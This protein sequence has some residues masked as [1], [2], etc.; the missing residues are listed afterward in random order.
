MSDTED[1][2]RYYNRDPKWII[3]RFGYCKECGTPLAGKDTFYYPSSKSAYCKKCG[4]KHY[5]D[6]MSHA[7]DEDVYNGRGVP[8][9]R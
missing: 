5:H 2:M 6:F 8:Y 9:A 7:C 4:E 1:E 3:G